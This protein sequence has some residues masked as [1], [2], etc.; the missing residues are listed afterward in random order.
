[1]RTH[2][3]SAYTYNVHSS[4]VNALRDQ[5]DRYDDYISNLNTNHQNQNT[6]LQNQVR[7]LQNQIDTLQNDLAFVQNAYV[8]I[9]KQLRDITRKYRAIIPVV[10]CTDDTDRPSP[11]DKIK[12]K[13]FK[14]IKILLFQHESHSYSYADVMQLFDKVLKHIN[15]D[16][17]GVLDCMQAVEAIDSFFEQ[18]GTGKGANNIKLQQMQC[19]AG[20]IMH[21]RGKQLINKSL[22]SIILPQTKHENRA[23]FMRGCI[24]R[25]IEFNQKQTPILCKRYSNQTRIPTRY[26]L[27]RYS[28]DIQHDTSQYKHHQFWKY[29]NDLHSS[30]IE[31][32]VHILSGKAT[33]GTDEIEDI[34]LVSYRTADQ[35]TSTSQKVFRMFWREQRWKIIT[36]TPRKRPRHN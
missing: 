19:I 18:N 27:K 5:I 10:L 30:S 22:F 3:P 21:I 23:S 11:R 14:Y 15:C 34:V 8:T 12:T 9:E 28:N 36:L 31:R 24:N 33:R 2:V 29:C 6:Q 35:S 26:H 17:Y 7:T 16:R 32:I 4:T 20:S 1:M 25:R 13:I